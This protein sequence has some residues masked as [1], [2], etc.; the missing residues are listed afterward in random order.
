MNGKLWL[1]GCALVRVR[2]VPFRRVRPRSRSAILGP[3]QSNLWSRNGWGEPRGR[4][5]PA[6][7][8][9]P[10][11]RRRIRAALDRTSEVDHLLAA[12]HDVWA[13]VDS[14][15]WSQPRSRS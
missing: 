3:A 12:L 13:Q 14:D 15:A 11:S 5:G 7:T 9:A 2:S 6:T 8:P 4:P 10:A 1:R